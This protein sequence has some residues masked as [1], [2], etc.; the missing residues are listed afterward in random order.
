[1]SLVERTSHLLGKIADVSWLRSGFRTLLIA[2]ATI[3]LIYLF[4]AAPVARLMGPI[5]MNR[6]FLRFCYAA[7][8]EQI[9]EALE[10]LAPALRDLA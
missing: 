4:T 5:R 2:T 1:M 8:E 6:P 10:W 9:V 7:A 3:V